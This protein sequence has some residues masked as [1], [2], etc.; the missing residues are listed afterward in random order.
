MSKLTNLLNKGSLTPKDRILLCIH[1]EIEKLRTGK[2]SL[3]D[4]DIAGIS[5]AWKP[6]DN[7]EVREY[8]LYFESW[9]IVRLF[10]A[11]AQTEYLNAI[12]ALEGASSLCIFALYDTSK[13]FLRATENALGEDGQK[14]ALEKLLGSSGI[15]Y[16][17]LIH[18]IALSTSS[19][20]LKHDVLALDEDGETEY[21]YFS[22]EEKLMEILSGK[23]K[24]TDHDITNIVDMIDKTIEWDF[25]QFVYQKDK[26]VSGI[27]FVG[28]FASMSILDL[29]KQVAKR[30]SISY[31]DDIEMRELLYTTP[32]IRDT[33]K[34]VVREMITDGTL[35]SLYEPLCKS[36]GHATFSGTDTYLEHKEVLSQFAQEKQKARKLIG[37]L[38][39]GGKLEKEIK[40]V[41]ATYQKRTYVYITG[42]SLYYL[43]EKYS[44]VFDF[45]KQVQELLLF[46]LLVEIIKRNKDFVIHY[47]YLLHMQKLLK[48]ASVIFEIDLTFY[49]KD[50]LITL[51][52]KKAL[53]NKE[54][55][56]V[57]DRIH[58]DMSKNTD[59]RL[60]VTVHMKDMLFSI[61]T[62]QPIKEP[63]LSKAVEEVN[64]IWAPIR[65][66]VLI[67]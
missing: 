61:D 56:M 14:E 6:K 66:D 59:M 67:D 8:N 28:Y 20:E 60:P 18:F 48:Q 42:E 32:S 49:I 15:E 23:E 54:L 44:F 46:G 55:E 50:Y 5:T 10:R 9:D 51:D 35:F 11:D 40:E 21:S 24:L 7:F 57:Y 12:I 25:M 47:G 29:A 1:S 52:E 38:L 63:S 34:N 2:K 33:F 19:E 53:L 26:E 58:F 13:S 16:E 62:I 45:K 4:A 41:D 65:K 17:A 27:F 3:S 39:Q 36:T 43:D 22:E 31:K 30:L 37:T 64:K